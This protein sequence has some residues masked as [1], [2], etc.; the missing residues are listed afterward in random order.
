[1]KTKPVVAGRRDAIEECLEEPTPFLTK[2]ADHAVGKQTLDARRFGMERPQHRALAAGCFFGMEPQDRMRA[3]MLAL[4][5]TDT[6]RGVDHGTL[7]PRD[8]RR[9]LR[10]S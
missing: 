4:D 8:G 1:M 6:V 9:R 10:R 2:R 7:P 3:R 5:E